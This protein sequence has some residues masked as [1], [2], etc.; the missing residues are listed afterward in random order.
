[1]YRVRK[2]KTKS[3]SKAIQVVQYFGHRSK[4]IKHIGSAKDEMEFD[5]LIKNAHEWIEEHTFQTNLFP[6]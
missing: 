5:L 1:M 6:E 4:I 2:V 3:G